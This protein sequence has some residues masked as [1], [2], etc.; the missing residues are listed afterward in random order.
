MHVEQAEDDLSFSCFYTRAPLVLH[1]TFPQRVI[2]LFI[3]MRVLKSEWRQVLLTL[4][5]GVKGEEGEE[6]N[7]SRLHTQDRARCGVQSHD[8][9]IIT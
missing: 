5:F 8:P 3:F 9:K 6:G 7:L 2:L 1:S 4:L